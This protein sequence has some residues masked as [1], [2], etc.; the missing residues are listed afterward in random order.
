[1]LFKVV[2]TKTQ[3]DINVDKIRPMCGSYPPVACRPALP[4]IEKV[5]V[6]APVRS[7]PRSIGEAL[8]IKGGVIVSGDAIETV[9]APS[10]F[11]Q[12]S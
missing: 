7:A 3:F 10:R 9:N 5:E 11:P 4:P 8:P 2:T 12:V 1:M 6:I